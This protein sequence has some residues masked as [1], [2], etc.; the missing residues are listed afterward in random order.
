ML[1]R[2][3]GHDYL[4]LGHSDALENPL[5]NTSAPRPFNPDTDT[6]TLKSNNPVRRDSTMLPA[7]G[8]VVLAFRTDNP[9][10][11]LMHCHIAWHVSQCLS[12]DF[13]ER[14]D[15]IPDVMP[16]SVLN[17]NCAAWKEYFPSDPFTQYDSGL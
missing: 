9:G 4:V 10:S 5:A 2:F 14:A 8:W 3:Q 1:I 7:F 15:E 12:V 11:W 13:L 16:L 6:A 17:D